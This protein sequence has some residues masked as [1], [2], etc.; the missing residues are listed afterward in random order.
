M[1]VRWPPGLCMRVCRDAWWHWEQ[2]RCHFCPQ[3]TTGA[4]L[5]T[6]SCALHTPSL[7]SLSVYSKGPP[8]WSSSLSIQE[9][10]FECS[11]LLC[12]H[13][14]FLWKTDT[15]LSRSTH[16]LWLLGILFYYFNYRSPVHDLLLNFALFP[17]SRQESQAF[18][19]TPIKPVLLFHWKLLETGSHCAILLHP[20]GSLQPRARRKQHTHVTHGRPA[21]LPPFTCTL[22]K[23]TQNTNKLWWRQKQD[24]AGLKINFIMYTSGEFKIAATTCCFGHLHPRQ[25]TNAALIQKCRDI[26][27]RRGALWSVP[28]FLTSAASRS[29]EAFLLCSDETHKPGNNLLTVGISSLEPSTRASGHSHHSKGSTQ[30]ISLFQHN[31]SCLLY[32]LRH[33]R[34]TKPTSYLQHFSG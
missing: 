31:K 14:I 20:H 6:H 22:K 30:E 9:V 25:S 16:F 5:Q 13:C 26:P 10:G 7:G 29:V 34:T 11:L 3:D 12:S 4:M 15:Q 21:E 24:N 8:C 27:R 23:T 2:A 32:K 18:C 17:L 19:H 28:R 1:G 33:Q